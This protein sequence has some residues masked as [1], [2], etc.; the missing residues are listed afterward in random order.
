MDD[1]QGLVNRSGV[2]AIYFHH[3]VK[4]GTRFGRLPAQFWDSFSNFC[5]LV[6]KISCFP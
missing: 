3:R 5:A 6:R 4:Q 1:V 2:H